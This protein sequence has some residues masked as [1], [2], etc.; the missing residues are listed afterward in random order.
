M[1]NASIQ[2]AQIT[3]RIN[4]SANSLT[5]VFPAARVPATGTSPGSTLPNPL[6]GPAT[7]TPTLVQPDRTPM[8]APV[9]M[10]CLWQFGQAND[11]FMG[12]KFDAQ[13]WHAEADALARVTVADAETAPGK[14]HFDACDHVEFNGRHFVVIQVNPMGPGFAAAHSYS[15]WLKTQRKQ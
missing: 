9:T 10:K 15:I 1:P 4:E 14:T 12:S 8:H 2:A 11:R 13:G 6:L 5:V 3:K 7:S